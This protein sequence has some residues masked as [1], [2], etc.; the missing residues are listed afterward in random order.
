MSYLYNLKT[1]FKLFIYILLT[2]FQVPFQV[3]LSLTAKYKVYT[4]Y[5]KAQ[6]NRSFAQ[7]YFLRFESTNLS[8]QPIL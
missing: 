3:T 5:L 2:T 8:P 6:R 1:N 7:V 4:L